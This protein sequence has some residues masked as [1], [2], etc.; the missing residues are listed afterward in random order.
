MACL[1]ETVCLISADSDLAG[2][3]NETAA[4]ICLE[5]RNPVKTFSSLVKEARELLEKKKAQELAIVLPSSSR[6]TCWNEIE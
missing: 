1:C 2:Q 4:H 6:E 5:Q 3:F